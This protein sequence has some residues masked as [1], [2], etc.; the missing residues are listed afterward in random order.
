MCR[1]EEREV[2][3]GRER[4]TERERKKEEDLRGCEWGEMHRDTREQRGERERER[5]RGGMGEEGSQREAA[6]REHIC[7]PIF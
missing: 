1:G 7:K 6:E 3:R 4:E 5:E 2:E